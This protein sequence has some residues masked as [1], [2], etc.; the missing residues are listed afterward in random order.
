MVGGGGRIFWLQKFQCS[1][2]Q[3]YSV[4]M[5]A[6]RH[7]HKARFQK[8]LETTLV[9]CYKTSSSIL[10]W[11]LSMASRSMCS[12]SIVGSNSLSDGGGADGGG[13]NCA[14]AARVSDGA[15]DETWKLHSKHCANLQL[16]IAAAG[17]CTT[18]IAATSQETRCDGLVRRKPSHPHN[19]SKSNFLRGN[20]GTVR[21]FSTSNL[22]TPIR[23][24]EFFYVENGW[25]SR[26]A[27]RAQK[28]A[29]NHGRTWL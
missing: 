14:D 1:Q 10:S 16:S 6:T 12:R 27:F 5:E 17:A 23:L 3:K 13:I 29:R 2:F 24:P 19:S 28:N 18:P 9:L 4:R 25:I 15:G 21:F 26:C 8:Q 11:S 7:F 20:V 22:R